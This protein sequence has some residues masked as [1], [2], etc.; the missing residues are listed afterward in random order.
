MLFISWSF[1]Q[2]APFWSLAFLQKHYRN[3]WS[4]F[5]VFRFQIKKFWRVQL[6][7]WRLQHWSAERLAIQIIPPIRAE[8]WHRPS[9]AGQTN[10]TEQMVPMEEQLS[11][12]S[13]CSHVYWPLNETGLRFS[14]SFNEK[15]LLLPLQY[16]TLFMPEPRAHF[17][18]FLFR[19]Y[20]LHLPIDWHS[21]FAAN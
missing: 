19:H 2:M 4:T 7:N 3:T 1:P 12:S 9:P 20:V 15:N 16:P 10:P 5:T 14:R 18:W 6:H 21:V 8:T 17:G 11:L 13:S